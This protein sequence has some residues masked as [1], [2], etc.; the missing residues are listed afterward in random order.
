MAGF[1][2]VPDELQGK[3]FNLGDGN[4][5]AFDEMSAEK[6]IVTASEALG[7]SPDEAI[8][9]TKNVLFLQLIRYDLEEKH[10]K[11]ILDNIFKNWQVN[12]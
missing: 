6:N 5:V 9:F 4:I 7:M 10:V 1:K 12:K 2:N 8:Q 11:E 3:Q